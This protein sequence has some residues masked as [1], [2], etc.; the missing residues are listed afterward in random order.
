[1]PVFTVSEQ[2]KLATYRVEAKDEAE[3]RQLVASNA[4]QSG[5][6][7]ALDCELQSLGVIT[8]PGIILAF[9]DPT[10]RQTIA[11]KTR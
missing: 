9:D 7:N 3:A 1:M 10:G 6:P 11:I 8:P 2:D 5:N 4:L